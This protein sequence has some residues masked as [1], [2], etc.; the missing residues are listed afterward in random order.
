MKIQ[1]FAVLKDFFKKEFELKARIAT[2]SELRI[3][4]G[5]VNPNAV[6]VLKRCRFAIQD[7]FV[8]DQYVLTGDEHIIVIP[9]SSGG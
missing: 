2:I 3:H 4:L 9:P 8:N 1:V 5:Q 6:S 7:S